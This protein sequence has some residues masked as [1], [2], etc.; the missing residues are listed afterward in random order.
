V[1]S[2]LMLRERLPLVGL[3]G[4]VVSVAGVIVLLLAR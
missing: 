3:L 4:I 2:L 1:L